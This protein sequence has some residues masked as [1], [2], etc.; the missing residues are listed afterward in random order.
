MFGMNTV[1]G[2][3]FF[4]QPEHKDKLMVTSRFMS[5]QGEGP[6]RGEPAFF[7]R[8]AFCNLRCQFCDTYFDDGEWLTLEQTSAVVNSTIYKYFNGNVPLWANNFNPVDL[9]PKKRKMA[10]VVTGG[11][12]TL[13]PMLRPLLEW[14]A[15]HF[16]KTQIESNGI[17]PADVPDSTIVVISPKCA[18]RNGVPTQYFTPN[19]QNLDRADCLKFVMEEAHGPYSF[20]PKWAHIWADKTGK[21]IFISPM[22]RYLKEPQKAKE[23]R[24]KNEQTTLEQRSTEDEIISAWEVGLLDM[25]TNRRNHEYAAR[26][27]VQHGFIFGMQIHL[28]ASVA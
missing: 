18:E 21:P 1:T 27:A 25:D 19:Q 17:L 15:N 23:L 26:Y 16:T 22:N 20:I 9:L 5:L 12:P 3:K 24:A 8:L 14:G 7:I 28:F 13:Q 2:R 6:L 10:L 4:T 11:E